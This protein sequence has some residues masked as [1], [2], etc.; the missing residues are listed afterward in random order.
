MQGN[1]QVN[2]QQQWGMS[3]QFSQQSDWSQGRTMNLAG[4]FPRS[5]MILFIHLLSIFFYYFFLHQY[6]QYCDYHQGCA[7]SSNKAAA[8]RRQKLFGLKPPNLSSNP[9]HSQKKKNF[10]NTLLDAREI[11]IQICRKTKSHSSMITTQPLIHPCLP[12]W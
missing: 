3:A 7:S 6:W 10:Q 2:F 4:D 1:V 11:P 12:F 9:T 5:K 8:I